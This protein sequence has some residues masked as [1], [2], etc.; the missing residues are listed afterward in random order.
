MTMYVRL[1]RRNQTIFLH[2]DMADNFYQIKQRVGEIYAM[3]PS[4]IQLIGADKV[5]SKNLL[6]ISQLFKHYFYDVFF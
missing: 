2:I 3:D 5:I 1:K 4:N 6:S